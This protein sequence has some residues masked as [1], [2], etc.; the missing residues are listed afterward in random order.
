MPLLVPAADVNA[1]V[2]PAISDE[3]LAT[4]AARGSQRAFTELYR[5]HHGPLYRY[6]HAILRQHDDAQDAVQATMT[7]ALVALESREPPASWRAWLFSI[8]R[9]ESVDQLRRRRRH[10]GLHD[11]ENVPASPFERHV[12]HRERLQTALADLDRLPP[13]QR[14][15][16]VLRE[17]GGLSDLEIAAALGISAGG[18][19]QAVFEARTALKEFG[20]GR[21]LSCS[22]VRSMIADG[23]GRRLRARQVGAHLRSCRTCNALHESAR[24]SRR[25]VSGLAPLPLWI[26]ELLGRLAGT[27]PGSVDEALAGTSLAAKAAFV[28]VAATT[29]GVGVSE[30]RL[31][32]GTDAWGA[33]AGPPAAH[34]APYA[35]PAPAV[36]PRSGAGALWDPPRIVLTTP[37]AARGP[38]TGPREAAGGASRPRPAGATAAPLTSAP[39]D[40]PAGPAPPGTPLPPA[41]AAAPIAA[42]VTPLA[43]A[44]P[45]GAVMPPASPQPPTA[46][47]V[48]VMPEPAVAP[49]APISSPV[50]P[51]APPTPISSPVA[52]HAPLQPPAAVPP[53]P[54]ATPHAPSRPAPPTT[55]PL[56]PAP[57]TPPPAA[58]RAPHAPTDPLAPAPSPSQPP[59]EAPPSR[60]A[61]PAASRLP[62]Q[63]Q[64][65]AVPPPSPVSAAP[66]PAAPRPATLPAAKPSAPAPASAPHRPADA[67][68]PSPS[69]AAA[70]PGLPPSAAPKQAQQTSAARPSQTAVPSPPMAARQPAP[71]SPSPPLPGLAGPLEPSTP[72]ETAQPA[73]ATATTRPHD[74]PS[75][76]QSSAPNASAG[77]ASGTHTTP[78]GAE[79]PSAG[80]SRPAG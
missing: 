2:L 60:S 78:A 56:S 36:A 64:P 43:P 42:P 7:R 40:A 1:P 23:D 47:R 68:P 38:A 20:I 74:A 14:S 50:A 49:P 24:G 57:A 22:A 13:R 9:N 66:L 72:A 5:R 71:Q 30:H 4:L 8:A 69:M 46:V 73:A 79:S 45:L 41:P 70:A 58:A 12:E 3:G 6:C 32:L 65:P 48:P 61:A 29:L 34:I 35:H 75:V 25:S 37:R 11:A 21:E 80:P 39:L 33:G 26:H 76:G 77:T 16:L 55:T 10:A 17:L 67:A 53:S 18:V 63:P 31:P 27:A 28:A 62:S 59:S 44:S 15:A 51:D 54:F 19:R 52:P